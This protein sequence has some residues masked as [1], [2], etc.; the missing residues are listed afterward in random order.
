MKN[1]M[2]K[3]LAILMLLAMFNLIASAQD[4][5]ERVRFARGKTSA[6]VTR[7]VSADSG[8]I[9]FILNAR[10]GQRMHF[11]VDS[12][13]DD[14]GITL[15]EAGQQDFTLESGMGEPNEFIVNKTG[16][17]YITVVN[18]SNSDAEITLRISIK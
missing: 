10:K 8:V 4:G 11:T 9:T 12:D 2:I 3:S 17:H 13:V 5:R 15:S 1:T 7:T 18:H 16:D 14:L 6:E